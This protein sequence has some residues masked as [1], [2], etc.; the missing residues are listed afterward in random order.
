MGKATILSHLGAGLYSINVKFDNTLIELRKTSIDAQIIVINAEL[1]NLATQKAAAK[2]KYDSDMAALSIYIDST[3]VQDY[4]A[5]PTDIN[6]L[7]SNVYKSKFDYEAVIRLEKNAKLRLTQINKD[8]EYLTNYC[9]ADFTTT[10]WCTEY[11]T[12]LAGDVDTI[13]IDYGMKRDLSTNQIKNDTGFWLANPAAYP[14][15]AQAQLQH[16]LESSVHAVWYNLAMLPAM[17]RDLARYR[18]ATI[19]DVSSGLVAFDGQDEPRNSSS[20]LITERPVYPAIGGAQATFFNARLQYPCADKYI[21]GD[22]VIVEMHP[23]DLGIPRV[24]GFVSNPRQCGS[25]PPVFPE[26][27]DIAVG[28]DRFFTG[29]YSNVLTGRSSMSAEYYAHMGTVNTPG[30]GP[31]GNFL[32]YAMPVQTHYC[33]L[34]YVTGYYSNY[35]FQYINKYGFLNQFGGDYGSWRWDMTGATAYSAYYGQTIDVSISE[36]PT[37]YQFLEFTTITEYAPYGI[38]TGTIIPITISGETR[39]YRPYSIDTSQPPSAN[40]RGILCWPGKIKLI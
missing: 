10:A 29:V 20:N 30:W 14:Q 34:D 2:A 26:F 22:R 8:K 16:P 27:I 39:N 40:F 3:P 33:M 25:V 4:S 18:I 12:D 32:R 1:A 17:Q 13:E 21:N 5:N 36:L 38:A 24:I 28:S 35:Y 7:T 19:I 15:T 9:P 37:A 11:K 6:K 31:P 23:S